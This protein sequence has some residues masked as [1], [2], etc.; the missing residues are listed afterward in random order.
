MLSKDYRLK[1]TE[2]ACRVRLNRKTTLEERIW[3]HKLIN[4]NAHARSIV[5]SIMCPDKIED[6]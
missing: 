1:V 5:E 6:M 3:M 4:H 2:I